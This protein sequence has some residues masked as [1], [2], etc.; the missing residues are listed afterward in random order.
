MGWEVAKI[1]GIVSVS[2]FRANTNKRY[3]YP[4]F[5]VRITKHYEFRLLANARN[6][7]HS[8]PH[9]ST[10]RE[11]SRLA[12]RIKRSMPHHPNPIFDE[13]E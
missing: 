13:K 9:P 6:R 1:G 11:P 4:L 10:P 3:H 5:N 7:P 2:V 12:P 8:S